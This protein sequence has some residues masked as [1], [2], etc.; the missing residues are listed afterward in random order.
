MIRLDKFRA[1]LKTDAAILHKPENMAYVLGYKGEGCIFVSRDYCA[2]ITDFRYIEQCHLQC[3]GIPV[4]RTTIDRTE[5]AVI[6]QIVAEHPIGTLALE[7]DYI[8]YDT[9]AGFEKALPAVRLEALG[10]LCADLREFKDAGEIECICKAA[11]IACRAFVNWLDRIHAG[12]TEKEVRNLLNFEMLSLGSEGEAFKTIAAAGVNGALPHAVP[13]DYVIREGDLLTVDFGATI[14]GYRSDTTRT[15]GFG[16]ISDRLREVYDTVLTAQKLA[17]DAIAPGKI[18][19]DIDKIARDYIDA[20]YPEC[21]GHSLGH[22]VGLFIHEQ[23]R[24]GSGSKTVLRPGHVVTVEPGVYIPGVGGCRIEDMAIM[25]S[26]GFINPIT[27]PK[28]LIEL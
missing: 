3:P 4:F 23:P 25:T 9:Y 27:A 14:N 2:V 12:M 18:C 11:D 20:R 15:V 22:G 26:D 24:V 28:E 7:T 21:F 19:G 10:S 13:T 8:T 6:A 17:L 1:A 5:N 16:R